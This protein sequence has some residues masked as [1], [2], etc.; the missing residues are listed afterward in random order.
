MIEDFHDKTYY[1]P[2]QV[3]KDEIPKIVAVL[4]RRKDG[5]DTIYMILNQLVTE[6]GTYLVELTKAFDE[7]NSV[8][9]YH[10]V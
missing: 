3:P 7:I 2:I 5:K 8:Y 4:L 9:R 10:F 6:A 1:S